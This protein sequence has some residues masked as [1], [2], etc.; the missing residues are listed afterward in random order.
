MAFLNEEDKKGISSYIDQGATYE[1]LEA[2][3]Y[4]DDQLREFGYFDKP[5]PTTVQSFGKQVLDDNIFLSGKPATFARAAEDFKGEID[6]TTLPANAD[7][8]ADRVV[9]QD[10]A[11]QPVYQS[12]LGATYQIGWKAPEGNIEKERRLASEAAAR[13]NMSLGDHATEG[14]DRL[15]NT[16]IKEPYESI[17]RSVKG[18][19]TNLD[20]INSASIPLGVGATGAVAQDGVKALTTAS[21]EQLNMFVGP[22]AKTVHRSNPQDLIDEAERLQDVGYNPTEVHSATGAF[23]DPYEGGWMFEI[24]D[25][26]LSV[27][28]Q[29]I[30]D[31]LN[32][33]DPTPIKAKLSDYVSHDQLFEAYPELQ[34]LNLEILPDS[35]VNEVWSREDL[36]AFDP[37][38]GTLYLRAGPDMKS[39]IAHELQHAVD[40]LEGRSSGYNPEQARKDILDVIGH[41]SDND[42][43]A[44]EFLDVYTLHQNTPMGTEVASELLSR[45]KTLEKRFGPEKSKNLKKFADIVEFDNT[46]EE[47]FDARNVYTSNYGEEKARLVQKRLAKD[48]YERFLDEPTRWLPTEESDGRAWTER[49]WRNLR[50]KLT[51]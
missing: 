8:S 46:L 16:F 26:D 9:A 47:G 45:L 48:D 33:V 1:D 50:E 15:F 32:N 25:K 10:D 22:R 29:A 13:S 7:P 5:V 21:P 18:Q 27:P 35:L 12:P 23:R 40:N 20:I 39:T 42:P 30:A 41:M 44:L 38:T 43:E 51:Q 4:S 37:R 19:G 17:D 36:G 34:E 11:G 3:G 2:A 14:L 28:D 31:Y 49:Q 24:S 6:P